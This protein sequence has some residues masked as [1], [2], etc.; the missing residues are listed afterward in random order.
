MRNSSYVGGVN[1]DEGVNDCRGEFHCS[2][3][4]KLRNVIFPDI[5]CAELNICFYLH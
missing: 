3:A 1:K 4:E 2:M 5:W